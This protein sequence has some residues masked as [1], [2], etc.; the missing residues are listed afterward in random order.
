M[1]TFTN[2]R[3]YAY[4]IDKY[5]KTIANDNYPDIIQCGNAFDVRKDDWRLENV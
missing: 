2:V 4:E 1:P 5:A 3:Y